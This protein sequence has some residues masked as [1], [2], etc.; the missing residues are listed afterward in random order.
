[1][2]EELKNYVGFSVD[3]ARLLHDAQEHI[4][5][6][7]ESIVD[8]FYEAI[9]KSPNARAVFEDDA[10]I[11]RQKRSLRSWLE[12]LFGGVYDADYLKQRERIGRVHV[13]VGL[14]QRYMFAAMNV[15]R[16]GLHG[17]VHERD[18]WTPAYK[19]RVHSAIDKICDI[20]LAIMLETYR[21]AY[22]ERIQIGERLAALGQI[23]GAIAHDLRNP[24]AVIDTSAHLL[25]KRAQEEPKLAKHVDRIAHQ[26]KLIDG[27]ITSLLSLT[28]EEPPAREAIAIS[29]LIEDAVG[30]ARLPPGL[31]LETNVDAGLR[32][33]LVEPTQF[34]QVLYNLIKNAAEALRHEGGTIHIAATPCGSSLKLVVW[35]TGPGLSEEIRETLFHPL[36]TTK[37]GGFGLGLALCRYVVEKH[38]GTITGTN[39]PQGGAQ[40]DIVVPDAIPSP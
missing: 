30:Q 14:D 11:E 23:A 10:Q 12:T 5:P 22:M 25:E 9:R 40:F 28:R 31:T 17:G 29:T 32:D 39:R 27:I 38:L 36:V 18:S 19:F 8:G 4:S 7:F 37:T 26:V 16:A 21:D 33:V 24:L 15:V 20:E 35:D 34:R 3:D 6:F 2:L 1:M 13:R